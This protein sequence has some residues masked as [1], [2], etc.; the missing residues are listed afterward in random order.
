MFQIN[1][2]KRKAREI[3]RFHLKKKNL[4]RNSIEQ[5][6]KSPKKQN[7]RKSTTCIDLP[8]NSLTSMD[9]NETKRNNKKR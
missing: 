5:S 8:S 6:I 1:F 2:T 3:S 7:L 4:D 9:R